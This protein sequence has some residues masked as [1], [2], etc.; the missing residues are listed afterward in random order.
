MTWAYEY[1]MYLVCIWMYTT[2]S[3]CIRMYMHV[4][5]CICMYLH[6]FHF[7]QKSAKY[8]W[9][10]DL[11]VYL[12]LGRMSI[13]CI[14]YVFACMWQ[15]LYVYVCILIYM[16][17]WDPWCMAARLHAIG[18]GSPGDRQGSPGSGSPLFYI[19][20]WA[21]IWPVDYKED[22]NWEMNNKH[23]FVRTKCPCV[24][25]LMVCSLLCSFGKLCCCV[26]CNFTINYPNLCIYMQ[27]H[28]KYWL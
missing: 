23:F 11:G 25:S 19:N 6:V 12:W 2:V 13:V 24:P 18:Q 26:D 1:C 22:A 5:V 14:W 3:V 20:S 15:Y 8:N 27:I 17:V 9:I 21:M 7:Q 16:L 10:P 28:A 4:Y